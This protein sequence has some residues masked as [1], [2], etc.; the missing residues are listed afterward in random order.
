LYSAGGTPTTGGIYIGDL[1]G[2]SSQRLDTGRLAAY[3]APGQ[4]LLVR[5]TVLFA[6]RFDL[7][8]LQ[9]SGEAIAIADNLASSVSISAAMTGTIAYRTETQG[10]ASARQFVWVDRTG[11]ELGAVGERMP[12]ATGPSLSPDGGRVAVDSAGP[13]G[14]LNI[15]TLETDRGLRSRL[16]LHSPPTSDF[17]PV[18]SP[19]GNSIAF[20]SNVNE[21]F[22][23]YRKSL[24]GQGKEDVLLAAPQITAPSDWSSDGRVL[25]YFT[26]DSKTGADVMGLPLQGG[27]PFEVVRTNFN[28]SAAQFSPDAKWIAYRSDKSGRSEVYVQPFPLGQGIERMISSGGGAQ[29]R[30]SRDGRELFYV[31]LDE[32]LMVASITPAAD[33]RSVTSGT[34]VPLFPTQVGGAVSGAA[35]Q[36]YVV[37]RD[38]HRFLMAT[39]PEEP[40]APPITIIL[41]RKNQ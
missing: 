28:E 30:W 8:S 11:K 17:A 10:L 2:T 7:S 5:G 3:A 39:L 36:Q 20:S 29:P 22:Q 38:G 1:E 41:N 33:G 9:L 19:D 25:L 12:T 23:V 15:W 34:P 26:I 6:Q 16:T 21:G 14:N 32:Q 4:L 40:A 18:W 31:A 27:A 35:E 13:D 37:S 24:R